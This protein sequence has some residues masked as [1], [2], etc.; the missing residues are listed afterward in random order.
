M[1]SIDRVFESFRK[2]EVLSS[3]FRCANSTSC[4]F[5]LISSRASSFRASYHVN[6][7]SSQA[8]ARCDPVPDPYPEAY[9]DPDPEALAKADPFAEPNA[10]AEPYPFADPDALA[11][12]DPLAYA[13]ALADAD[14]DP[15]PEALGILS[16]SDFLA[17]Y[18][19]QVRAERVH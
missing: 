12:P 9:A 3:H 19:I 14:P 17:I 5:D 10:L 2:H 13:E 7:F 11:E 8:I 1:I 15:E 18:P 6:D 16:Y 4:K